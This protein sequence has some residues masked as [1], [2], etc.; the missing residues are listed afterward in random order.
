LANHACNTVKLQENELHFFLNNDL[1]LNGPAVKPTDYEIYRLTHWQE[2]KL[3][4]NKIKK[5]KQRL[6]EVG[7]NI[8][9]KRRDFVFSCFTR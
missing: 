3:Q 7:Y 9:V 4:V 5:I 8:R 1:Q 2:Y 6:V